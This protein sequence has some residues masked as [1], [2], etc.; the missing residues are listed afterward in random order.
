V[1]RSGFYSKWHQH[2]GEI[3]PG[4]HGRRFILPVLD[5]HGRIL[6]AAHDLAAGFGFM[7]ASR[8]SF[9]IKPSGKQ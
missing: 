3:Y 5:G 6:A 1:F 8:G 4:R 2:A 7:S 9:L